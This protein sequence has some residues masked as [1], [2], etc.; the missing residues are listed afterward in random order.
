MGSFDRF[1]RRLETVDETPEPFRSPLVSELSSEDSVQLLVFG[2]RSE[3]FGDFSPGTVLAITSRRWIVVSEQQRGGVTVVSSNFANTL[4]VELTIVLLFGKLRIAFVADAKAQSVEMEFNTVMRRLYTQAAQLLLDKMDTSL[5]T[6]HDNTS[7]D[8]M[9]FLDPLPYKF[10]NAVPRFTPV[11]QQIL[12]VEYWPALYGRKMR[13]F[14]YEV[15]P[16]GVLVLTDRELMLLSEEKTWSWTRIARQPKHGYIVTHC[17]LS[18]LADFWITEHDQLITLQL[19]MRVPN[20]CGPVG[21]D[22]SPE[23][24]TA[25]VALMERAVQVRAAGAEVA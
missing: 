12:T 17:P 3:S 21:F 20:G 10:R 8:T 19:E 4:F 15:V 13:F 2:P 23:Q 18:R 16:E 6:P 24:R 25:V 5:T 14:Q 7:P 11:G 1:A 9:G 22:L